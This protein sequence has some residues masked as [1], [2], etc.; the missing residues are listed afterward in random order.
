MDYP[1]GLEEIEEFGKHIKMGWAEIDDV[2]NTL[3]LFPE[4]P[5]KKNT[6]YNYLEMYLDETDYE[7]LQLSGELLTT[8]LKLNRNA[9]DRNLSHLKLPQS[10]SHV[11]LKVYDFPRLD[12]YFDYNRVWKE[13]T[14][15]QFNKDVGK[16]F[17]I[18][19][20]CYKRI[21]KFNKLITITSE[22]GETPIRAPVMYEHGEVTGFI[23]DK[24]SFFGW[25]L[26]LEYIE[27]DE[28]QT[29]DLGEAEHQIDL[30]TK[31]GILHNSM[32]ERN[33]IVSNGKFRIIDF[34]SSKL[35]DF[36]FASDKVDLRRNWDRMN[37]RAS[38]TQNK[39][40][41]PLDLSLG[42]E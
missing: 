28:V 41:N 14:R 12:Y 17:Y 39:E 22:L 18:E 2:G 16:K 21:I 1:P 19:K 5:E 8:V 35:N 26:V 40:L 9:I 34:S 11:V 38:E 4:K 29:F 42:I 33:I 10:V 6:D 20:T 31:L 30:L 27:K 15:E 7:V 24:M 36:R 37:L 23:N 3:I 32:H 13:N 25:Y